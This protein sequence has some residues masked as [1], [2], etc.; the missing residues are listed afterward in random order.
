MRTL[1][2][3]SLRSSSVGRRRPALPLRFSLALLMGLTSACQ[4]NGP[5]DAPLLTADSDGDGILDAHEGSADAD[6]DSVANYQDLD[7]DG[8]E[9]AD[10]LEAG[11]DVLETFPR[12]SDGDGQPD[13]LD[14]DSD[15]NG[16]P[17]LTEVGLDPLHP[18]DSDGNGLPDFIDP[19]ND[20]DL[21]SDLLEISGQVPLDTDSDG[22]PD[23]YDSDS[24]GDLILD[25]D[26]AGVLT[27]GGQPRDSD[28][29][30]R[31]DYRDLDS[32]GDGLPDRDEAGDKDP[33]SAPR[34]TDQDGVGDFADLDS[35][36]DALQ[37]ADELLAGSNPYAYDTDGDG[38][39]DGVER[40]AGSDPVDHGHVPGIQWLNVPQRGL[41]SSQFTFPISVGAADIVF[42]LDNTGSMSDNIDSLAADFAEIVKQVSK[43]IPNA[44]FGIATY[45]T[46][47]ETGLPPGQKPHVMVQQLTTS[48]GT[49]QDAL[50]GLVANGGSGS[51][52]ESLYQTLTGMGYDQDCDFRYDNAD[53]VPP[54]I[55]SPDDVFGG[56]VAGVYDETDVSTGLSGGLGF[57]PYS[58]PVLVYAADQTPLDPDQGD[59]VPAACSAPSSSHPAGSSDVIEAAL[60]RGARIVGIDVDNNTSVRH[61]ME[62]LAKETSSYYDKEGTGYADD[63]LVYSLTSGQ[64]IATAVTSGISSL[65]TGGG[66]GDVQLSAEGDPY[67]FIDST[68][69]EGYSQV[70]PGTRLTFEVQFR[71]AVAAHA[72][73]Q[74]FLIQLWVVGD[75]STR[76]GSIP[77]IIVVPGERRDS[78][79]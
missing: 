30:G 36:G 46:Y 76:L 56:A 33:A 69:P 13:F 3:H 78:S 9:V 20:G 4:D 59:L 60:Q 1:F 74:L 7:S 21:I 57:R 73:D 79:L 47:H 27:V 19:D 58:L 49:V 62:Y 5:T 75:T 35:D 38:A 53:D 72:D 16:M 41:A 42:V 25:R 26:E 61:H 43:T 8:D 66:F 64:S 28:S 15:G 22:I 68:I 17:D 63:L 50:D 10:R 65:V 77:A 2:L 29:D 24:D 52:L 45:Q 14:V 12:D 6:L 55:S 48:L 32:D 40:L 37:D 71:G 11:D 44:A 54:F 39:S 18:L 70:Q 51:A 67:G 34:D 23:F 31:P